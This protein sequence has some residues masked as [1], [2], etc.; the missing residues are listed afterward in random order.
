MISIVVTTLGTLAWILSSL[1]SPVKCKNA[2]VIKF[3]AANTTTF[4]DNKTGL[5]LVNF[6]RMKNM[7]LNVTATQN[8]LV[9]NFNDCLITCVANQPCISANF[10]KKP[11]PDGKHQCGLIDTGLFKNTDKLQ[12]NGDFDFFNVKVRKKY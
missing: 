4:R 2:E 3:N 7:F 5:H 1:T 12:D 11:T 8:L 9:K 10:A 6:V